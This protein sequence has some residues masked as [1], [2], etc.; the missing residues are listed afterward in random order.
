MARY[1]SRVLQP[2]DALGYERQEQDYT[3]HD[4]HHPGNIC[5]G[6]DILED[7]SP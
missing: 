3:R 6:E 4:R 2:Q 5:R 1:S 7:A